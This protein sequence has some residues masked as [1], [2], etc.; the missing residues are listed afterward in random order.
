MRKKLIPFLAC[1]MLLA[2]IA[3]AD[4]IHNYAAKGE[5][6]KMKALLKGKPSL[7]NARDKEGATPLHHAA[8]G[9]QIEIVKLLIA[10]KADVNAKKKD[11]VTPLHVAAALGQREIATLLLDAKADV[12]AEDARKRTPVGVA[13]ERGRKEMADLLIQRG[14]VAIR[15]MKPI[16]QER[17]KADPTPAEKPSEVDPVE[18]AEQIVQ[19]LSQGDYGGV[20][21]HFDLT[22][23]EALP[24][25]KLK[26]T[27]A[28]IT[29][30]A[31]SFRRRIGT[32]T[33]KSSQRP[34]GYEIVFVTC[35]FERT[36]LDCQ[37]VLN[38]QGKISGLFIVPPRSPR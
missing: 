11:G 29:R 33:D 27:W 7:V 30:Q 25:E 15:G 37:V 20:V 24:A 16:V 28:E 35:Q 3:R 6:A 36:V 2:S 18:L 26:E 32:R 4:P 38:P 1:C 12:N 9:G 8:A 5:M 10:S 21:E 17:R 23:R 14:G 22:M 34:P 19:L 13:M 31:G